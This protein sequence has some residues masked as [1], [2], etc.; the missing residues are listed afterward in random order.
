MSTIKF[1]NIGDTEERFR[2]VTQ[3]FNDSPVILPF[4][5]GEYS[6]TTSLGSFGGFVVDHAWIRKFFPDGQWVLRAAVFITPGDANGVTLDLVYHKDDGTAVVLGSSTYTGASPTKVALGPIDLFA[7]LSVPR[8]EAFVAVRLR[9]TKVTSGT[10]TLHYGTIWL[11]L[12][13]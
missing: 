7:N 11:E 8:T 3:C 12:R 10:G 4:S 6:I 1:L 2:K 9:G 13:P 5:T